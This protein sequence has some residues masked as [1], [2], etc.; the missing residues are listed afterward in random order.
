MHNSPR[1][2]DDSFIPLTGSIEQAQEI[3][4]LVSENI[5]PVIQRMAHSA[6]DDEIKLAYVRHAVRLSEL[7]KEVKAGL[8]AGENAD[9]FRR[10]HDSIQ[11]HRTAIHDIQQTQQQCRG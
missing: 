10:I 5:D 11:L 1:S 7:I 3:T 2:Q 6:D 4:R 9:F 8:A